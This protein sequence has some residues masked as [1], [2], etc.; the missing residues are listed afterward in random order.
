V[1]SGDMGSFGFVRLAPRFTQG[2]SGFYVDVAE[3]FGWASAR[4]GSGG[5]M[6]KRA[7]RIVKMLGSV[8][9]VAAC[10]ACGQQFTAPLSA[11]KRL[12]DAQANLQ[13][14][15]DRHQCQNAESS[16]T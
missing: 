14:Q 3:P 9:C 13:Q 15:F 5:V 12:T 8:P 2:D 11:L 6:P 4:A 1:A 7:V 10:T 16:G